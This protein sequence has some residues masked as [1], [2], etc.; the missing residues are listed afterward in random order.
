MNNSQPSSFI[1]NTIH[2]ENR[3]VCKLFG[4]LN[5]DF[6]EID[7]ED[8]RFIIRKTKINEYE[9]RG[10]ITNW[11]FE[12]DHIYREDITPDEIY[13][14]EINCSDFFN[15][16]QEGIKRTIIFVGSSNDTLKK[17][18]L[19]TIIRNS[20]NDF[21]LPERDNDNSADS[22]LVVSM[23]WCEIAQRKVID[24]L[25]AKDK[26]LNY[27]LSIT[28]DEICIEGLMQ[29][30]INSIEMFDSI[31]K[32]F[33]SNEIGVN[34]SKAKKPSIYR[35]SSS[36]NDS[37]ERK[38]SLFEQSNQLLSVKYY[39]TKTNTCISKVNFL[40]YRAYEFNAPTTQSSL[41]KLTQSLPVSFLNLNQPPYYMY[42]KDNYAFFNA[43]NSKLSS[44]SSS[45]FRYIEDTYYQ[46]KNIFIINVPIEIE[47]MVLIHDLLNNVKMRKLTCQN[48]LLEE[49][50]DDDD[51][52]DNKSS[53]L[54]FTPSMDN[55]ENC[56]TN[57]NH[58]IST[59]NETPLL[60]TSKRRNRNSN[61]KSNSKSNKLNIERLKMIKSKLNI[62]QLFKMIDNNKRQ[63][64]N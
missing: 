30:E 64:N 53:E 25:M 40:L 14:N 7:N 39:N 1:S 61:S 43:I 42:T 55:K 37:C 48:F 60:S 46:G 36:N 32:Q 59:I 28:E 10:L 38:K 3:F 50:N 34:A 27:K 11:E 21:I 47:Y 57:F 45:L 5:H 29:V 49:D 16:F 35:Y 6:I 23:S 2:Y 26:Q 17:D 63:S 18:P 8:K 51:K 4:N 58:S 19:A 54:C 22:D 20:L 24:L 33:H 56:R 41:N 15:S 62:I 44:R 12:L 31:I 13:E 9:K 52:D